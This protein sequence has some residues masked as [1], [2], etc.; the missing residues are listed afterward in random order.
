MSN[1]PKIVVELD[2]GEKSDEET[3]PESVK[4]GNVSNENDEKLSL[5]EEAFAF[6]ELQKL[7]RKSKS[8]KSSAKNLILNHNLLSSN[9]R[10]RSS[11]VSEPEELSQRHD[12]LRRR[13][14][15]SENVP[16]NNNNQTNT[17]RSG[18]LRRRTL[19]TQWKESWF[20]INISGV[21]TEYADSK[22]NVPVTSCLLSDSV[23][24]L[25]ESNLGIPNS[26]AL[27]APLKDPLFLLASDES[28]VL[29]WIGAMAIHN[30]SLGG[31]NLSLD[32]RLQMHWVDPAFVCSENGIILS[33]NESALEF[34]GYSRDQLL[35]K[36]INSIM[37]PSVAQ[38]HDRL[39]HHYVITGSKKLIGVPRK[40]PFL[41]VNKSQVW[42]YINI[43]EDKT[44][45]IR[46]FLVSI[47]P[48]NEVVKD[49]VLKYGNE[50]ESRESPSS[51]GRLYIDTDAII[52][53]LSIPHRNALLMKYG[54]SSPSNRAL[55]D[56]LLKKLA[57]WD[58]NPLVKFKGELDS[59]GKV[60]KKGK[61]SPEEYSLV[62]KSILLD[63]HR[64]WHENSKRAI[65]TESN[66]LDLELTS[67]LSSYC[68]K[69]VVRRMMNSAVAIQTPEM[70]HYTAAVMFADISGFT[71]LTERLAGEG[72]EGVEKLTTVL[73][74]YFGKLIGIINKYGGD[75]IKFAGDAVLVIWPTTSRP[76]LSGMILLAC[77]CAKALLE[78]L[79]SYTVNSVGSILRLHIGIGAGEVS[80]IHIGGIS[81]RIEFF[82]SGQV[83]EQVSNCE[84][85]AGPGEV[86]V[87]LIAWMMVEPG[88]LQGIQRGKGGFGNYR[89]DSIEA[90]AELPQEE[91]LRLFKDM[92]AS[93]KAYIPDS[94]LRHIDS[95]TKS[96]LAELRRVSVIFLNLTVPFKDIHLAELQ[97]SFT[98][99][100]KIIAKYE[101]TIRQFMIDDKGSVLIV[102]FG[103]PPLSHQDDAIRAVKTALEI[104]E[105]LRKL[106]TPCAIGVT[107]GRAFCGDIGTAARREYA[108][109]G[110]IVNMAARLMV[111]AKTGILTDSDTFEA[112]KAADELKF[113]RL[114][115]IRVKGKT[116]P[117]AVFV[118]S[119][120]TNIRINGT[121][122]SYG[123]SHILVGRDEE[124][125][126]ITRVSN[127]IKQKKSRGRLVLSRSAGGSESF[128]NI[129]VSPAS[130]RFENSSS[131]KVTAAQ[132]RV[133]IFE[134]EA[135]I[136][137]SR[138]LNYVEDLWVENTTFTGTGSQLES[139]KPYHAWQDIFKEA[140]DPKGKLLADLES[141]LDSELIPLLNCVLPINVPDTEK[142]KSMGGQ[143]RSEQTQ[144][145]LM[146]LLSVLVPSTSLI[147]MENAQWLDSASWGLALSASQQMES[148]L[149]VIAMRPIKSNSF[150]YSQLI[151]Q[152][153][154]V[155][156]VLK[157]LNEEE[158]ALQSAEILKVE[159][160]SSDMAL[161]V[162]EKSQGNPFMTQEI[163]QALN[164]SGALQVKQSGEC[165]MTR[166][167]EEAL[168]SVPNSITGLL[169]SKVDRLS[170]S[171]QILLKVAS[172]IGQIFSL[173]ILIR[174]LPEESREE[175]QIIADLEVLVSVS[176][177]YKEE[178]EEGLPPTW[179]FGNTLIRDVVYNIMLFS[180]RRGMHR[181]LAGIYTR[182]HPGNTSYYPILAYHFKQSEEI[183]KAIDYYSKAGSNCLYSYSYE[184]A[185]G[186][187]TEALGLLGRKSLLG[188]EAIEIERKL[189]HS[190]Y[191]LGRLTL[192]D[193]HFRKALEFMNI[194]V[195]YEGRKTK[196][197]LKGLSKLKPSSFTFTLDP[198]EAGDNVPHRKR[199]AVLCLVSLS[200]LHYYSDNRGLAL[201]CSTLGLHFV[202]SVSFSEAM[203]VYAM[204]GLMNGINSNHDSAESYIAK[205]RQM[206]ITKGRKIDCMKVTEL[207]AAMYYSGI[208]KW[209]KADEAFADA[210]DA[211]NTFQDLRAIEEL[212]IFTGTGLYYRGDIYSSLNMTGEALQSAYIRGD[213]T[214]QILALCA[215]AR[216]HFAVGDWNSTLSILAAIKVAISS[217]GNSDA[218]FGEIIYNGLMALMHVKMNQDDLALAVADYGLDRLTYVEPGFYYIIEEI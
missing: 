89:L 121:T 130:S 182:D 75:I 6:E 141:Q 135:G 170:P 174:L 127:R 212:K 47:K 168:E 122:K 129:V 215:Q 193:E 213:P 112:C 95:G 68:P 132:A 11:T 54:D 93:L 87:S 197:I 33:I 196:E 117:I 34:L 161:K 85:Q 204:A 116:N 191:C 48:T 17:I 51:S 147:I 152:D 218:A 155:R 180:Q 162:H 41:L 20:T 154:C 38:H 143:M 24:R 94:V 26:F 46:R 73:N 110:D 55:L 185:V 181:E 209:E 208:C 144:L 4:S 214:I 53:S 136:G 128:H 113:E 131:G 140:L 210:M 157:P 173:P 92:E 79:D 186:F 190:Y 32:D 60:K 3:E 178:E 175:S 167:V 195:P 192:A 217:S 36:S 31:P 164:V 43:M 103:P 57:K 66:S 35:K 150:Q 205:G 86:Y 71:A 18:P 65:D 15:S 166:E 70:E 125:K 30:L 100:Q 102:G 133:L 2:V 159:K 91:G 109:V 194:P 107:T 177:L 8:R 44:D 138:L 156:V 203:E 169:T 56:N 148:C 184:E 82:I 28:S 22:S 74:Q 172:V 114:P 62:N 5:K 80:G 115:E 49:D 29:E 211:A 160:I 120:D 96:W 37:P 104:F 42:G 163:V 108:M 58:H 61:I 67:I 137:K 98:E 176:I 64:F 97:T 9:S 78:D 111:A 165:I 134:G 69:L 7:E 59:E 16:P 99:M 23:V 77:Q 145:I 201:Y 151:H 198:K 149:F 123:S 81:N 124:I 126:L 83:L 52:E 40:V 119:L 12:Q 216:N 1:S 19:W 101:G 63:H 72:L 14:I 45:G 139:S 171:Q 200:K 183:E 10:P 13:S 21:L 158:T 206:N 118:P 146:K 207:L 106:N 187:F 202:E 25:A 27:F 39:L 88:R 189:A 84:K 153:Y 179:C 50:G 76:G 105:K 188:L 142:I 199:E 90:P